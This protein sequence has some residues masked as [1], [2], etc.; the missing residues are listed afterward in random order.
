MWEYVQAQCG[1]GT[2]VH[3]TSVVLPTIVHSPRNGF[4]MESCIRQGNSLSIT[5]RELLE[6]P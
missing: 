4:S 3:F 2:S 1:R 5:D 6:L